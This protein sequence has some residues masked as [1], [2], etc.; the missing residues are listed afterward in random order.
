MRCGV[1]TASDAQAARARL[2]QREHRV[3]HAVVEPAAREVVDAVVGGAV[4]HLDRGDAGRLLV[5]VAHHLAGGVGLR[6]ARLVALLLHRRGELGERL[7]RAIGRHHHHERLLVEGRDHLQVLHRIERPALEQVLVGGDGG[8]GVDVHGVAVGLG[9][10]RELGRDIAGGADLVFHDHG[11][12]GERAQLFRKIAHQH[13][14]AASGREAADEADV[15][16]RIVLRA[17]RRCAGERGEAE[18]HDGGR[19]CPCCPCHGFPPLNVC[20]VG[21]R[22]IMASCRSPVWIIP[23]A[24]LNAM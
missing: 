6:V 21:H 23:A 7:V 1:E 9:A 20:S 24:R 3:H 22:P 14:G 12:A 18:R 17:R 15:L 19:R 13:V 10:R 8:G 11:A 5:Q 2:R 16:G 4:R